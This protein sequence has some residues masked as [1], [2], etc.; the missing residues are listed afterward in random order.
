MKNQEFKIDAEAGIVVFCQKSHGR[1]FISKTKVSEK[2]NFNIGIGQ[3]ITMKRNEIEI[4]KADIKTM[5]IVAD[6]C[7]ELAILHDGSTGQK[8]YSNFAQITAEKIS[9]SRNHIRELKED[10][11]TLYNGTYDVKPYAEILENHKTIRN[12][13]DEEKAEL[14]KKPYTVP[15]EIVDGTHMFEIVGGTVTL[16]PIEN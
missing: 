7:K 2:D 12:G 8:L 14:L 3:L 4:R 9:M 16:K 5:Q 6:E 15:K 10:L 13:S 11:E 1:V